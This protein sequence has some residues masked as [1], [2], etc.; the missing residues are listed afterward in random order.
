MPELNAE[1]KLTL[2]IGQDPG[3]KIGV[4]HN[5]D[6]KRIDDPIKIS[7]TDLQRETIQVLVKMLREDRL[8]NDDEVALLGSHLYSVLFE[9]GNGQPNDIGRALDQALYENEDSATA[10]RLLRVELV[11]TERQS[12]LANWPLEYL[13]TP[14]TK[15]FLTE[16][17]RLVLTRELPV[18]HNPRSLLV[19][20]LPVKVLFVIASP[21]DLDPVEYTSVFETLKGLQDP[22]KLLI[23]PPLISQFTKKEDR[24]QRKRPEAT[25]DNFVER[26]YNDEPHIIHFI[27]HGK[28]EDEKGFVAFIDRKKDRPQRK[29]PEATWDNFVERVYNDEPHIIHFIGHGKWEDEKGF[30]AFMKADGIADWVSDDELGRLGTH[31]LPK[32]RLVFLQACES[33][34]S[35]S[36]SSN[37]YQAFSGVANLLAMGNIPAVVAMQY[38]IRMDIANLFARTFYEA[39]TLSDPVDV[40]VQKGRSRI[41]SRMRTSSGG[42]RYDFCLPV[43]YL[44]GKGGQLQLIPSSTTSLLPPNGDSASFTSQQTTQPEPGDNKLQLQSVSFTCWYCDSPC[45]SDDNYCRVCKINLKCPNCRARIKKG[46]DICTGCGYSIPKSE[47]ATVSS[48][49]PHSTG[50]LG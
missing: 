26:V 4:S 40:A 31:E 39:L 11:F 18:R 35:N 30:V 12:F 43:L 5:L 1:H 32:L 38:K 48:K 7:L 33:A 3:D 2:I 13:C 41:Q 23:L 9:D 24:P 10:V 44:R 27:G 49:G 28:W 6:Y 45:D 16:M 21:D 50:N 25:W 22:A 14:R 36:N 15:R 34:F 47:P 8:H 42:H 19:T 20:D 46:S 17:T 29:R 37:T